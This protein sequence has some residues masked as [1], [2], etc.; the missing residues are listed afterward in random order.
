MVR[1]HAHVHIL[2]GAICTVVFYEDE[3]RVKKKT[4]QDEWDIKCIYLYGEGFSSFILRTVVYPTSFPVEYTG[5]THI[6]CMAVRMQHAWC[7]I[8]ALQKNVGI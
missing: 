7:K 8:R 3:E 5:H 2:Q 1:K 4:N 6:A